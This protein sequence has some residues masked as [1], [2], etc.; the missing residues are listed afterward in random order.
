MRQAAPLLLG[1]TA[2]VLAWASAAPAQPVPLPGDVVYHVDAACTSNIASRSGLAVTCQGVALNTAG[3]RV[4]LTAQS[5]GAQNGPYVVAAGAWQQVRPS[6]SPKV[7]V[8]VLRG[9]AQPGWWTLDGSG[10]GVVWGTTATTWTYADQAPLP[11]SVSGLGSLGSSTGLLSHTASNTWA[12]RS[13]AGPLAGLSITNP[14]GV[15]GDPTFALADDLLALEGLG[16]AGLSV[17]TGA[18]AWTCRTLASGSLLSWTNADGVSG[19]PSIDVAPG[20]LVYH[21]ASAGAVS[22]QVAAGSCYLGAP[23]TTCS[24]TEFPVLIADRAGTLRNLRAHLGTAA[25]GG[26]TST[27]V[28]RKNGSSTSITCDVV[29]PLVE[30]QDLT[31]TVSVATGDRVGFAET[32]AAGSLAALAT[33]SAV[34]V[35]P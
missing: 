14:A 26:R 31:H 5:S 17:R 7:M 27:F 24:A 28:V 18:S 15:G 2:G 10:F 30:C 20:A 22:G 9:S 12:L 21:T 13:L 1:L 35:N 8:A 32:E 11:G 19:A 16:C 29:D 23:G 33:A 34:V 25:G 6:A 3:M 4:L